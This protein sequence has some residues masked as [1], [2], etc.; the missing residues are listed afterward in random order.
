VQAGTVTNYIVTAKEILR[1][2][3]TKHIKPLFQ[4]IQT[5][6]EQDCT[7]PLTENRT[8][9]RKFGSPN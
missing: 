3:Q 8:E 1:K 5:Y 7:R 9:L 4:L 6:K 2:S